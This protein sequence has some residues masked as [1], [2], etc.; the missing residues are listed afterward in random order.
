MLAAAGANVLINHMLGQESQAQT[1]ADKCVSNGACDN[2]CQPGDITKDEEC[3]YMVQA[4]LDQ[5]GRVDI[6]IN[7]AGFN[8]PVEHD[9][10]DGLSAQNFI[11]LYSVHVIGA[12]Q[13]IRA[14]APTMKSQGTGVVVNVSSGSG[15]S[16]YGSSVAYSA[17]KGAMNTLTKSL[18]RALA[19]DIRVNAVCPGM[20]ITPLWDKLQH[21]EAQHATWLEAVISEIPLKTEPTPEIIARSILYLASDLS[22]HLTGQLITVD[23][24][25][26][27]GLYQAMFEQK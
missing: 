4:A 16:G 12:Y 8:K 13:M 11:D 25:T 6:L 27:L 21:T 5:W 24:G 20:V 26:S 10:L 9:D 2:L 15:E 7:N 23:G 3:K 19:P 22:A 14:V 18:G 1:V 17:S